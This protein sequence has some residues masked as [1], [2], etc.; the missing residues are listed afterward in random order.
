MNV[1]GHDITLLVN[2]ASWMLRFLFFSIVYFINLPICRLSLPRGI[3][4]GGPDRRC[5]VLRVVSLGA[6]SE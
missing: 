3:H 1:V 6:F 5:A 2:T 4:V